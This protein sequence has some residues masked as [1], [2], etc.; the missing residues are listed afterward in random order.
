L[1]LVVDSEVGE[2]SLDTDSDLLADIGHLE[3]LLSEIP[4]V[5]AVVGLNMLLY[6]MGRCLETLV[7]H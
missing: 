6:E 2:L 1:G 7:Y 5:P 4:L 3:C